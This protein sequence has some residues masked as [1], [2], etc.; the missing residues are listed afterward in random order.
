MPGF[1]SCAF[2]NTSAGGSSPTP[3]GPGQVNG[4]VSTYDAQGNIQGSVSIE[5]QLI[6]YSGA[7][8]GASF[9][10]AGF[11][12]TSNAITGLLTETFAESSRYR[13][14]RV[15]SGT[16]GAWVQFNTPTNSTAF[17]LPILL[18]KPSG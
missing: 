12:A 18:G 11:W 9:P 15:D 13:G 4:S 17:A 16:V 6:G 3:P 2:F 7:T 10:R 8:S 14:R 5:F 1:F